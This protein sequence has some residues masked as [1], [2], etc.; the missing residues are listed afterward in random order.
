VDCFARAAGLYA[1]SIGTVENR[2]VL[3]GAARKSLYRLALGLSARVLTVVRCG[4]FLVERQHLIP[5]HPCSRI[6]VSHQYEYH[7][8]SG[9]SGVSSWE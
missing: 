3:P 1:S 2:V 9:G 7:S 4:G 5:L 6:S 8:G